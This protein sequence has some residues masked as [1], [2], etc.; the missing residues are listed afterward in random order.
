MPSPET[1]TVDVPEAQLQAH[2]CL[3]P[4]ERGLSHYSDYACHFCGRKRHE[5]ALLSLGL[6]APHT[7]TSIYVCGPCLAQA[8]VREIL[9]GDEA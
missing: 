5:T 9:P 8:G 1:R 6:S 7:E 2:I 3:W 4:R